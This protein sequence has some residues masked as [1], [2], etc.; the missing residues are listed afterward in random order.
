M[1]GELS[2]DLF[3]S[4]LPPFSSKHELPA[5]A[6]LAVQFPGIVFANP[7]EAP[8]LAVV[9]VSGRWSY[10]AGVVSSGTANAFARFLQ[11]VFIP[12]HRRQGWFEIYCSDDPAWDEL[13]TTQAKVAVQKHYEVTYTLNLGKFQ[14]LSESVS[15]AAQGVDITISHQALHPAADMAAFPKRTSLTAEIW[16]QGNVV[17][18]CRDNGLRVGHEHFIDVDTFGPADR[19]KGLATL[20]AVS[21]IRQSPAFG[22]IP[23][24]ETTEQ[25]LASRRL[26]AKL[27]FEQLERYPV[28]ALTF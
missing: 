26:A 16:R 12:M 14:A 10:I 24:W 8:T 7:M 22:D 5:V 28:Y 17:A 18:V 4:V 15:H 21:L 1:F 19:Q 11:D 23:L 13:F 25:N 20:A 2:T 27:G 3:A 6:V 9:S